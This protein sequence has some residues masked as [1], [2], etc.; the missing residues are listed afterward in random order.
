MT[1]PTTAVIEPVVREITV[2][3]PRDRAFDTF[4]NM[5]AW[6]PLDTH[7]IGKAPARASIIQTRVGGRWYGIDADGDSHEIGH[8]LVFDPPSRLVLSWEITHDFTYDPSIRSEVEIT[9]EEVSPAITRVILEH[10]KLEVYGEHAA[11]AREIFNSEGGWGMLLQRF[12]AFAEKAA[13]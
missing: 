4:I 11:M 10:R 2:A 9:F 5:T 7:T 12:A 3:A 13:D 6:W 8:V 1:S